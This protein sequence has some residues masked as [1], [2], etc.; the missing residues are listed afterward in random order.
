MEIYRVG[1]GPKCVI[2]CHDFTGF[3]GKRR[4]D[5]LTRRMLKLTQSFLNVC[6]DGRELDYWFNTTYETYGPEKRTEEP[7]VTCTYTVH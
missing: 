1:E 6:M 2:W 7:F 4:S 5:S 3:A